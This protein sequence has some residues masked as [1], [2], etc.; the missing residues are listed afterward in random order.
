MNI[1]KKGEIMKKSFIIFFFILFT[2]S[3][4][5]ELINWE[6]TFT[7]SEDQQTEE[8]GR[9]H[10]SLTWETRTGQQWNQLGYDNILQD[11]ISVNDGNINN[12]EAAIS[13][14]EMLKDPNFIGIYDS[15]SI[16]FN[17]S[18]N[19]LPTVLTTLDERPV[20]L[21]LQLVLAAAIW[22]A[23]AEGLQYLGM[24]SLNS[25]INGNAEWSGYDFAASLISGA[26]V[27]SANTL[28]ACFSPAALASVFDVAAT[29]GGITNYL[30]DI[31]SDW[32]ETS[33]GETGNPANINVTQI[34]SNMQSTASTFNTIMEPIIQEL[35]LFDGGS[36]VSDFEPI[37]IDFSNESIINSGF[38]I[39]TDSMEYNTTYGYSW[40]ML[41][42]QNSY[43]IAQFNLSEVPDDAI[44]NITHLT[45]YAVNAPGYGYSPIDIYINEN[46]FLND[47]DVALSH[48]GSHSYENDL[49]QIEDYLVTGINTIY[50]RYGSN[51]YTHYWIQSLGILQGQILG[52]EANLVLTNNSIPS[53][54]P[55]TGGTYSITVVNDGN[56]NL[57]WDIDNIPSWV[58]VNPSDGSVSGCQTVTI[59]IEPN[60]GDRR[61]C[62]LIFFNIQNSWDYE[63][64]YIIQGGE[65]ILQI[66]SNNVPNPIPSSGGSYNIT[67]SNEGDNSCILNWNTIINCS[68]VS[69]SQSSGNIQNSNYITLSF[70][71]NGDYSDRTGYIRFFNEDNAFN[72]VDLYFNQNGEVA[73]TSDWASFHKNSQNTGYSNTNLDTNIGIEWAIQTNTSNTLTNG[74]VIYEDK[75]IFAHSDGIVCYNTSGSFE[76]ELDNGVDYETYPAVYDGILYASGEI[77]STL[78]LYAI[79][80]NTG[81]VYDTETC[82]CSYSP[83]IADETGIYVTTEIRWIYAYT[84]HNGNLQLSWIFDSEDYDDFIGQLRYEES[85]PVVDGAYLYANG[86]AFDVWDNTQYDSGYYLIKINKTTGDL[87]SLLSY[88]L[89]YDGGNSEV[90]ECITPV[91]YNNMIYYA[92]RFNMSSMSAFHM[93]N[94]TTGSSVSYDDLE[95]HAITSPVAHNDRI[96]FADDDGY[97]YCLNAYTGSEIFVEHI[98]SQ[99]I[100]RGL[101]L[102]DNCVI[103]ITESDELILAD[104]DTGDSIVEIDLPTNFVASNYSAPTITGN[105]IIFGNS[106]GQIICMSNESP[107]IANFHGNPTNGNAPMSV[108]FSDDSESISPIISRLWDFG[109]GSSSTNQNP[110]HVYEYPGEYTVSLTVVNSHGTNIKTRDNY[111]EVISS[112]SIEANPFFLDFGD[113]P[114][115]TTSIQSYLLTGSNLTGNITVTAPAGFSLST[116]QAGSYTS[117]LNVTQSGGSANQTVWVKFTPTQAS[118]YSGSITHSTNNASNTYITVLGCGIELEEIHLEIEQINSNLFQLTWNEVA[119]ASSYIVFSADEP[120]P[121]DSSGWIQI[122]E[123]INPYYVIQANESQK[124]FYVISRSDSYSICSFPQLLLGEWYTNTNNVWNYSI[125]NIPPLRIQTGNVY[126]WVQSSHFNGTKYRIL[127]LRDGTTDSYTFFFENLTS[128]TMLANKTLGNVWDPVGSFSAHHKNEVD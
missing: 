22:G 97:L 85:G 120:L 68:W 31:L 6:K 124:F 11:Y 113:Q 49:W 127:T 118:S 23:N 98:S 128:T 47:Y 93:K 64:V 82:F 96:Y 18:D 76:W 51:P 65:P 102:C 32:L 79:N 84:F 88:T 45:S 8:Q 112:P 90:I 28:I 59:Q 9:A 72:Y 81:A 56:Y 27:M 78:L 53:S 60:N 19:N 36:D 35:D 4:C 14:D 95:D 55:N 103:V 107:P 94:L 29:T 40:R 42:P 66:T 125:R 44:L 108:Q 74:P 26:T 25:L 100:E 50:I 24:Y 111:I 1:L 38:W 114:I 75:V 54:V 2:A 116:S 41:S 33:I 105:R 21:I 70:S 101:A 58:T 57:I 117:T 115:N 52:D 67:L 5:A 61:Y 48:G 46:Q 34:I 43:L 73:P 104:V 126:Y 121:Y 62:G 7:D 20:P 123:T 80:V 10:D 106:N 89:V 87:I 3:L 16:A 15:L 109:D 83:I 77:N 110:I 17:S 91:R 13:Y 63:Y 71:A 86:R 99:D 122:A 37:W 39:S 119:N 69:L 92:K 12:S 30:S